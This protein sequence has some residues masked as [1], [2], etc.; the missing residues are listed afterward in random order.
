MIYVTMAIIPSSA[1]AT[2]SI[3]CKDKHLFADDK[4]RGCLIMLVN[5]RAEIF[6]TDLFLC[7]A[8]EAKG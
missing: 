6:Q 5:D 1:Q 7:Y 4:F 3:F 2:K 8:T